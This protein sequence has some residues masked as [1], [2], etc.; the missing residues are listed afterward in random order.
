MHGVAEFVGGASIEKL[1]DYLISLDKEKPKQHT[2]LLRQLVAMVK[3]RQPSS[4]L[5]LLLGSPLR[6][7]VVSV[8]APATVDPAPCDSLDRCLAL[9][10][11]VGSCGDPYGPLL[12][13]TPSVQAEAQCE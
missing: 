5:G 13:R 7:A 8:S 1:V 12:C 6:P 10:I 3:E 9:P 11:L 4:L 2:H